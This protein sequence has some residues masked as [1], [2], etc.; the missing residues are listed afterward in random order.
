MQ[1]NGNL[2]IFNGMVWVNSMLG[3]QTQGK[4]S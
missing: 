4:S 3:N 1:D 2:G